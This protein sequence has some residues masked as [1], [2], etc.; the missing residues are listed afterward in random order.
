MPISATGIWTAKRHRLERQ[1]GFG[2]TLLEVMVTLVIIGIITSFAILSIPDNNRQEQLIEE[3]ERLTALLKLNRQEAILLGQQRG[4]RLQQD[5]YEFVV[6]DK[7]DNEWRALQDSAL[8]QSRQLAQGITLRASV[9]G[10]FVSP[11]RDEPQIL[12]LSSGETSEFEV[13]FN[14][15]YLRA[16]AVSGQF[17]GHIEMRAVP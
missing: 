14:G 10:H 3:A 8:R 4:L 12:L 16:Y 2:F 11:S 13:A 5:A 17:T 6:F 7:N 15:D 9:E 1:R